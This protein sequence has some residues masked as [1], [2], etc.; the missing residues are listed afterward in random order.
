MYRTFLKFF[1]SLLN[2]APDV[3]LFPKKR[4]GGLQ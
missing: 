2:I 4:G 3:L 1:N